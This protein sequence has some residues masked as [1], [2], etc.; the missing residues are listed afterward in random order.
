MLRTLIA[1]FVALAL[2]AC[3]PPPGGPSRPDCSNASST[4]GGGARCSSFGDAGAGAPC[5]DDCDCCGHACTTEHVC[6]VPCSAP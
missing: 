5:L 6:A 1:G 4:S 2:T 3:G